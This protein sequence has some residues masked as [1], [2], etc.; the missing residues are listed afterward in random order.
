[1]I[2]FI[3]WSLCRISI[4]KKLDNQPFQ[5]NRNVQQWSLLEEKKTVVRKDGK[6]LYDGD[7]VSYRTP[8]LQDSSISSD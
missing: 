5:I 2:N 4:R 6:Q 7:Y 3:V 1:M 8:S